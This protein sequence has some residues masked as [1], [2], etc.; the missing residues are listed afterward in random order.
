M[1]TDSETL[2]SWRFGRE[3]FE[4]I[5]YGGAYDRRTLADGVC[6]YALG[7]TTH[8][9]FGQQANDLVVPTSSACGA[10]DRRPVLETCDHFHYFSIP[11]L[12]A[13]LQS[14]YLGDSS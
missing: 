10:G 8:E 4:L 3:A 12:R 14:L 7:E 1:R 9:A 11:Y 5:T 13:E 2:K 6:A